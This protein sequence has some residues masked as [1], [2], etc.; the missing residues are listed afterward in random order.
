MTVTTVPGAEEAFKV[1]RP[2]DLILAE[3]VLRAS[4]TRERKEEG[5]RARLQAGE[6]GLDIYGMREKLAARGLVY[7]P[8][9]DGHAG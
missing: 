9:G 6:L 2:L 5:T 3:A 1:T 7:R 8:A 4:E